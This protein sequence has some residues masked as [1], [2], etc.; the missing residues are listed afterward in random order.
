MV[1]LPGKDVRVFQARDAHHTQALRLSEGPI[2]TV[3]P[4]H[5]LASIPR[6]HTTFD[7]S[8]RQVHSLMSACEA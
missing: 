2:T 3:A 6:S 7:K 5:T 8:Q 1:G 4:E